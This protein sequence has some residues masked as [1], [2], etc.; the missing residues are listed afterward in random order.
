M[1]GNS[2]SFTCLRDLRLFNGDHNQRRIAQSLSNVPVTALV[3]LDQPWRHDGL[4][5]FGR[6]GLSMLQV[7]RLLSQCGDDVV[8]LVGEIAELVL[9]VNFQSDVEVALSRAHPRR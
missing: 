9:R 1:V 7:S 6:L 2:F 4:E 8:E 5:Q 3:L